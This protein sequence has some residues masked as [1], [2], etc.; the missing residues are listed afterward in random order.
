MLPL[1]QD[2]PRSILGFFTSSLRRLANREPPSLRGII[3][4]H[5]LYFFVKRAG[6]RLYFDCFVLLIRKQ[7]LHVTANNEECLATLLLG[8]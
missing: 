7:Y 1:M 2:F 4:R 6:Q 8:I 5:K 3:E